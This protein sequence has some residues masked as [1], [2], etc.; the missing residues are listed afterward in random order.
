VAT[1]LEKLRDL[2]EASVT[3]LPDGRISRRS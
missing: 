3:Q 2:L 1:N